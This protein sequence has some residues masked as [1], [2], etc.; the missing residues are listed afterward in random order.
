MG[1]GKYGRPSRGALLCMMVLNAGLAAVVLTVVFA[2][3][4]ISH[5]LTNAYGTRIGPSGMPADALL[6]F[7]PGAGI[8]FGCLWFWTCV[9]GRSKGLPWVGAF[10]YG[11]VLSIINVAIA[12][13]ILGMMHGEPGLALLLALIA[14]V[15][16]FLIPALFSAICLFGLVMGGVNAVI[17]SIWINSRK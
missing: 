6:P 11:V 9:Y 10:I 12:G 8:M 7:L 3:F 13:F 17:A 15:S 2:L 14:L 1:H 5:V 16:V 4:D